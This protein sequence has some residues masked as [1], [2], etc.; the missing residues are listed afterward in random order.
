MLPTPKG[1]CP[2]RCPCTETL[3][4]PGPAKENT[5]LLSMSEAEKEIEANK[6]MNLIDDMHRKGE[7]LL[8]PHNTSQYLTPHNTSHYLTIPH[9][10]SQY[11]TIPHNNL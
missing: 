7:L 5:A 2:E 3:P 9:S 1:L 10:T 11:L 8:L 6:L 4:S